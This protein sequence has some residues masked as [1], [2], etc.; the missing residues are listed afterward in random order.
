M[1]IEQA[2]QLLRPR[3]CFYLVRSK[4]ITPREYVPYLLFTSAALGLSV[5]RV[6]DLVGLAPSQDIE[7]PFL[8]PCPRQV[9]RLCFRK[10]PRL[11]IG[12]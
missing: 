3:F 6:L 5:A 11:A 2:E 7:T 9:E 4:G 1:W 10:G 12:M 8:P